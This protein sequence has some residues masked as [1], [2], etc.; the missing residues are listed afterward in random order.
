MPM[1]R[2]RS[3][4]Q[5]LPPHPSRSRP[6]SPINEITTSQLRPHFYGLSSTT[7]PSYSSTPTMNRA[8]TLPEVGRESSFHPRPSSPIQPQQ[9][10]DKKRNLFGRFKKKHRTELSTP[11]IDPHG[12][13]TTSLPI[14]P[15][16]TM[17]KRRQKEFESRPT[18]HPLDTSQD[19]SRLPPKDVYSYYGN[20]HSPATSD[21]LRKKDVGTPTTPS[22][23]K[24]SDGLLSIDGKDLE[25]DQNFETMEGIVNTDN[26]DISNR[27]GSG[28]QLIGGVY[29]SELWA[30]PD[31]WAVEPAYSAESV[32]QLLAPVPA[33]DD[34]RSVYDGVTF[35]DSTDWNIKRRNYCIRVFRSDNTFGTL[36]LPLNTTTKELV[37]RLAGKFF[38]HDL[39]KYSL[40]IR[41]HNLDRVLLPNERP[42]QIQKQLLE[43]MGY[44]EEDNIEDV[45]REDNSYLL[46]FSFGTKAIPNVHEIDFNNFKHLGLQGRNLTT[47]PIFLYNYASEIVS[48][49]LT[50]NLLMEIPLDFMQSCTALKQLWL[51][52]NEYTSLPSSLHYCTQLEHLNISGN[53]LIDLTTDSLENLHLLKS[54]RAFNNKLESLPSS[55]AS[56]Q[57]L[58]LLYISNNCLTK[59][60][61]V[62]CDIPQLTYLDISFNKITSLPEEIGNLKKLVSFFAIANRLAGCLPSSFAQL[63]SLQELDL[64]QNFITDLDVICQLPNLSIL[65]MDYN[66]VSIV[67]SEIA[68]VRHLQMS[69]NHLTQFNMGFCQTPEDALYSLADR[70]IQPYAVPSVLTNLN[71]SNCKLSSFADDIFYSTLTLEQLTL[72]NNTLT[73]LPKSI[74]LLQ[75]LNRLSVQDN[76]LNGLP[77]EISKLTEL[78]V[79]LAQKNNLQSL[80]KEI[81]LCS[82]LQILNCSSNLLETFPEPFNDSG[83]ALHLPFGIGTSLNNSTTSDRSVRGQGM[84][85]AHNRGS[86]H[87]EFSS[88]SFGS[89]TTDGTDQDN[90]TISDDGSPGRRQRMNSSSISSGGG[91]PNFNPPS[92]FASPRNHPPPLSLS[93]RQLF[94]GDNR[95][96][97]DVW[98]PLSLFLELR[99]LNLAYN[100]LYEIPPEELCHQHLYELYLSGNTLT[101][102]PADDIEKLSY[103]RVLAVNDNKL[104]TLP[105]EIGKLRKLLVLDV[106]NNVLKYNI[107]NWP[108]DWNW[109]WN[110][111]LKYLNLSGNKRLEIKQMYPESYNPKE[112]NLS[113][114]SALTKLR[115]LGLMD[116]TILGVT[117]PEEYYDRR[118]RTSPS[119][120]NNM[121]YGIAD[122]L[123]PSDHLSTWDLVIPRFRNKDDECL[124]ALF[125]G[126]R[127]HKVGCRLTKYLN[128]SLTYHLTSELVKTKQDDTVVSAIRRTFLGLEK[129]LGIGANSAGS[130]SSSNNDDNDKNKNENS[131]GSSHT[132][133]DTS[134][135]SSGASAAV[136]YISG[137]KLYVANIGDVIVVL[138]RNNGQAHEITQKHIP[139]NPSETSRIRAAG[140]Y[141]SN[142]GLLNDEL[143]VSRSFG[144]FHLVPVVNANPYISVMELTEN[145]EFLIM[146]SQG[147]W[148][149]MSYQT[150]VD[151]ARTEKGDFMIA[152]QKL[153][154]FAISYGAD[155]NIMVMVIGV[156]DMFD[157]HGMKFR[158]YRGIPMGA[159]GASPFLN[160]RTIGDIPSD[161][162]GLLMKS[163]RRMKE[164]AGD[165]TLARLE[166]EVPPPINQVALVFTDI[167]NSTFLWETHQED[168]RSAI[169][170]HDGIMRRTLRSVGGYEVKTEGDAFMTCFQN[171]TGALLWCFTVQ[172][173]L[174]E[175]DWPAGIL[176]T[177]EGREIEDA[178]DTVI[179]RGL[180]VRMGI[181]WGTPVFERNPITNRMDYFGPVVNKAAR[182]CN[183]ADGGQI[184]VSSD[185]ITALRNIPGD[186]GSFSGSSI[187]SSGGSGGG[188]NEDMITTQ[189]R[190]VGGGMGYLTRDVQQLKRLG[191]QVMEL[192]ERRL[193]GLE[194]PE[195]LSFVYPKQLAGRI[196]TD[197]NPRNLA[198]T[199]ANTPTEAST[200]TTP[201]MIPTSPILDEDT[202]VVGPL[203]PPLSTDQRHERQSSFDFHQ[204][205]ERRRLLQ[206]RP[207][208]LPPPSSSTQHS[209]RTIDPLFVCALNDL[210]IRLERITT[211]YV[212][213]THPEFTLRRHGT[214]AT[215]SA[216]TTIRAT[217]RIKDTDGSYFELEKP[218]IHMRRGFTFLDTL[219][220]HIM[221]CASDDELMILMENFVTR[222]ENAV[223]TLYL[224]KVGQFSVVLEQL[225][226]ALE[227]DPT[228]VLRA[229]Q[230]YSETA[231]FSQHPS[232]EKVV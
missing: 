148:D 27:Q 70:H 106:G 204:H 2:R 56:F 67:S 50:K 83:V 10:K 32:S 184:C 57:H 185:V 194:T 77:S 22:L 6:V 120:V 4:E 133:N 105:A 38:L 98:S 166:R 163:K 139:L 142:S 64:R 63:E 215:A 160:G 203:S 100:E 147:L 171:I 7:N 14:A 73:S 222:I 74:G 13:P 99:T 161:E 55:F 82:S 54:L 97:D 53:Q 35:S 91:P 131:G 191:F 113:D 214:T 69:K 29:S 192:G 94:L 93:L 170:I 109:N 190:G 110:L 172:L 92:F 44:T 31:S 101:S 224:Q 169:K 200:A 173:Q 122:W 138:S 152:A 129:G 43:Q 18:P 130:L 145:D 209:M 221:Q 155:E 231:G 124:F 102:L 168:M 126:C 59:F 176:D 58:N 20:R 202:S 212:V 196:E 136:C 88:P 23:H 108:Y 137:T 33:T 132:E 9:H 154:D 199:T 65:F 28:S 47:V 211:G 181:H 141:V 87:P 228:H 115:M 187:S 42:F 48:L 34:D 162:S 178:E 68:H 81:W 116:V 149:C 226:D 179:Y 146:A 41:L 128:D 153:R 174:L 46:R 156:G 40:L 78:K 175:A 164:S 208:L 125:D 111:G 49:D 159:P 158:N 198:S 121:R 189:G 119:E 223:S 186:L 216:I 21:R 75:K 85:P 12:L 143:P 150:A 219:Q 8:Q 205:D 80:P 104:Q 52:D 206:K 79:L 30:P 17:S 182:I 188:D 72:D 51:V 127:H 103:L 37:N 39:S 26:L 95:L 84:V 61:Q 66:A 229:L 114:F 36:Q 86:S 24:S 177:E 89:M 230:M 16:P 210:A 201:T 225:G 195:T 62:I 217:T 1:P 227:L 3:L 96:T 134:Q 90:N 151:V 232:Y 118:V 60:P 197:K 11:I 220:R 25:L 107:A 117:T 71:L 218:G 144:Y 45:G 112:K 207:S 135:F 213:A 193:K 165:S 157:R 140:G 19:D 167:K 15:S 5:Q 183:A 180:S 123:G 76:K